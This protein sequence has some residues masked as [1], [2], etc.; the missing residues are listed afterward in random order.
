MGPSINL[1]YWL[2][3]TFFRSFARSFYDFRIVGEENMKFDGAAIIAANHVSFL[4]PPIIGQAFDEVVRSFARKTLF[5]HPLAAMILREWQVIPVDL[6][7]PDTASLKTTMRL[8]RSGEKIVMFPEGTRSFDGK[9]QKAEPGIGLFL[10]KTGAPVL[11]IRLFGTFEAYPRKAK[12]LR[13]AQ[14][15]LVVGQRYQPDLSAAAEQGRDLYQTLAD[16][17][18]LRIGGLTI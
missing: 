15:T 6:E 9:L 7:K 3:H 16:E 13:R 12:F 18:M 5:D 14:I 11:P 4:D 17:V 10:A 1:T 2:G 8:L